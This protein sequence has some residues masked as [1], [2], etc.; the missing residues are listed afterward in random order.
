MRSA[1]AVMGRSWVARNAPP[2]SQLP[3]WGRARIAPLPAGHR[4][5]GG[6]R[7]PSTNMC[8]TT[9]S[10]GGPRQAGALDPVAGVGAERAAGPAVEQ[11]RRR[12]R[13][14]PST[15]AQVGR[16][17]GPVLVADAEQHVAHHVAQ[18]EGHR[19]G[20]RGDGTRPA[21]C[22]SGRRPAPCPSALSP[23]PMVR[24][25]RSAMTAAGALAGSGAGLAGP[26]G[27]AGP[28]RQ[29]TLATCPPARRRRG[30][31][32]PPTRRR[33]GRR[34]APGAGAAHPPGDRRRGLGE[35]PHLDEPPDRRGRR[36]HQHHPQDRDQERRPTGSRCPR[37]IIRSARSIRPPLAEIPSDSALA[38]W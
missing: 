22:T 36:Q 19:L 11:R 14:A 33:R 2:Y 15:R 7:S 32:G 28:A 30:A 21:S 8:W 23:S 3:M 29:L 1:T 6:A 5:R 27:P 38:R 26:P 35:A 9:S 37:R 34:R 25:G 17:H 31:C 24:R 18:P 10:G 13:P 12:R 4:P 16:D 20:E